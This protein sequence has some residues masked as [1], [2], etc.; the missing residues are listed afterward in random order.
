MLLRELFNFVEASGD[1]ER[2]L[3]H[4]ILIALTMFVCTV[5]SGCCMAA[6]VGINNTIGFQHQSILSAAIFRKALRLSN[7]VETEQTAG[8][9]LNLMSNDAAKCDALPDPDP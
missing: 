8:E 1:N 3:W 7:V 6:S 2:P 9:I 5:C 4:G